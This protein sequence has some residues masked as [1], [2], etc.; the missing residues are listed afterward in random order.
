MK[1]IFSKFLTCVLSIVT[2]GNFRIFEMCENKIGTHVLV[3]I[4]K[5][6]MSAYVYSDGSENETV[7]L[8]SGWGT[9]NPNEDF[10][11]LIDELRK[12][13]LKVVVLEYFG[14]GSSD[15][16]TKERSNENICNEIHKSLIVLGIKCPIFIVHSMSG[17]HIIKYSLMFPD[18]IKAIVGVDMSLPQKQIERWSKYFP[19]QYLSDDINQTVVNHW[20]EFFNNSKEI[21]KSKYPE[22]L[23]VIAFI[24]TEQIDSVKSMGLTSWEEMNQN[25]ITNNEIQKIEILN[26][27]HYLHH[28]QKNAEIIAKKTLEI[29]S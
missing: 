4:D 18:E 20:N 23:P 11:P 28:E 29:L 26:G 5:R 2:V 14:Y 25:M 24:A 6:N 3:D 19:L 17:L 8:L 7:V 10:E 16:T 12:K 27:E 13:N 15:E 22:K 9:E 21:E 1:K